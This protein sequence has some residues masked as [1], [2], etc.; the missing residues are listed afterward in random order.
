MP[1][2][3]T[4]VGAELERQ[5]RDLTVRSILAYA[6]GL[7]ANEPEFLDDARL[8]GLSALPF[9]C[10]SLEWPA[11]VSLRAALAELKPEE[12][13]RGVHAVQDSIFHRPMRPGDQLETQGQVVAASAIRAG[14]LTL[15]RMDTT[16]RVSGEPVVTSWSS[17]IYRGVTLAGQAAPLAEPPRLPIDPST[18]FPEGAETEIIQTAREAPHVYSECAQ[19]W[20]PIHTER[21][22]ALAAGLPDIILHGTMTWALAGLTVLRRHAASD[23]RRLKR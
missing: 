15:I 6:A 17:S 20:N 1:F 19:I 4:A 7:G 14:V 8:G 9:Q 5:S 13:M 16:D 2:P 23:V 18:P 22:V 3:A 11:L 21:A 10:V 12:A